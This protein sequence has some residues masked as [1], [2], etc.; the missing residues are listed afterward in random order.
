MTDNVKESNVIHPTQSPMRYSSLEMYQTQLSHLIWMAK[1]NGAKD[2]AWHRAKELDEMEAF[3][4]I[5]ADL[6]KAMQNEVR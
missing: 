3:K 2:H 1:M 5:K 4:G 6:I